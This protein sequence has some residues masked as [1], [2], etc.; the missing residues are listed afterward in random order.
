MS[1]RVKVFLAVILSDDYIYVEFDRELYY[2]TNEGKV[3]ES[4][5]NNLKGLKK[6]KWITIIPIIDEPIPPRWTVE[7]HLCNFLG[8]ELY[9]ELWC[10]WG[11]NKWLNLLSCARMLIRCAFYWE[12]S[13][14]GHDF[15]CDLDIKWQNY[16]KEMNLE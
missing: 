10:E 11:G 9:D 3:F 6:N 1:E 15:W 12:H 4:Y 2:I 13:I 7:D 16:C 14:K 8:E 5:H